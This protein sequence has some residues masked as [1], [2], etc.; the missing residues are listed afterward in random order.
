MLIHN[1]A[2]CKRKIYLVCVFHLDD[3]DLTEGAPPDDLE[4]LEVFLAE[5]HGLDSIRHRFHW[6][7]QKK[8]DKNLINKTV[9]NYS[10]LQEK[11][12]YWEN[13]AN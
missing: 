8:I 4:Y 9:Q 5:S 7:K 2:Y 6:K 13:K 12:D 1:T 3:A 11:Q 10:Q